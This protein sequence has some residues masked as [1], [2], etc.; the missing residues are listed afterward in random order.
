VVD[1]LVYGDI[2]DVVDGNMSDSNVGGRRGRNIRDNLFIING[3]INYAIK[4]NIEIDINLY[5]I[6]KCFDA[7]WYQE[8]M[9]DMWDVGVQDDKFALMAKMNQKCNIAVKTP[10]GISERFIATEIEMQGTVVGPIKACVQ[11]GTMGRDCLYGEG[12]SCIR[13]VFIYPP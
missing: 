3:V 9:N 1:K 2:Y 6:A 10:A 12:C 7:M 5:E 13:E 8:T 11:V 4:E